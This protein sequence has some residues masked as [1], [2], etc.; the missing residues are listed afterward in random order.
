MSEPDSISFTSSATSG[1]TP[2]AVC[3]SPGARPNLCRHAARFRHDPLLRRTPRRAAG[4]EQAS[5]RSL[6]G[7]R[8]R[9]EQ[10]HAGDL[11]AAPCPRRDARREPLS[12]HGARPRLPI[13]RRRCPRHGRSAGRRV[14]GAIRSGCR[15][16]RR[17]G[18]SRDGSLRLSHW[19]RASPALCSLRIAGRPNR[20]RHN[21]SAALSAVAQLKQAFCRPAMSPCWRSRI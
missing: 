18:A 17:P 4:E 11:G 10:S 8:R 19:Q 6:A 20:A 3:S 2:A 14:D 9:G 15:G 7:R 21:D 16:E 5:G 13:R 1:W 12:R